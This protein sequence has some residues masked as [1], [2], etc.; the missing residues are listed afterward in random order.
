M[1]KLKGNKDTVIVEITNAIFRNVMKKDGSEVLVADVSIA[2]KNGDSG[3]A[4]IWL[5]EDL[6]RD[7]PS[8]TQLDVGL[9][10]LE[11]L[12]MTDQDVGN[13]ENCIGNRAEVY[14]QDKSDDQYERYNYFI[15]ALPQS[16]PKESV[17]AKI[18]AMRGESAP[19]SEPADDEPEKGDAHEGDDNGNDDLPW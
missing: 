11:K 1:P 3:T 18:A 4:T 10:L 2:N 9:E 12:G 19:V 16:E 14:I 13:I 5:S 17:R 8:K 6:D 7:N 15:H